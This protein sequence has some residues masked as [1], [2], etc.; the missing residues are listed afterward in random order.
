[1][2][3]RLSA[4]RHK[5]GQKQKTNNKQK[6]SRQELRLDSQVLRSSPEEST[7]ARILQRRGIAKYNCF[8]PD[9]HTAFPLS[10]HR[11]TV[12]AGTHRD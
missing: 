1:M 12:C 2:R 11:R 10:L 5:C 7:F 8:S 6:P 9:E 4:Q 3:P